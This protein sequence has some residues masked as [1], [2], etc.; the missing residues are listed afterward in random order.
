MSGFPVYNINRINEQ[1]NESSVIPLALTHKQLILLLPSQQNPLF[2]HSN[3]GII[4]QCASQN[5][6]KIVPY[7]IHLS[8]VWLSVI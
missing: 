6:A 8:V 2:L 5:V 4:M 7:R 3:G 1:I